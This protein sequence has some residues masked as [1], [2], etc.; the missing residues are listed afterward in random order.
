[1]FF[2]IILIKIKQNECVSDI[3]S[4]SKFQLKMKD[5]GVLS[6]T[7]HEH[8][9]DNETTIGKLLQCICYSFPGDVN[10]TIRCHKKY[11]IAQSLMKIGLTCVIYQPLLRSLN[12]RL[13]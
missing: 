13:K 4:V 2:I 6:S 10:C 11:L 3:I 1:M 5:A 7:T 12:L 8:I 9:F